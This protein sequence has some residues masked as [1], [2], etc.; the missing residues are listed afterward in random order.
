M[1]LEWKHPHGDHSHYPY[2]PVSSIRCQDHP[3]FACHEQD[4]E[5]NKEYGFL[6]RC[7][8]IGGD[9][10][11]AAYG[12]DYRDSGSSWGPA[13][14]AEPTFRPVVRDQ[15]SDDG[16]LDSSARHDSRTPTSA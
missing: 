6:S 1:K 10:F 5:E 2:D 15:A 16:H 13:W 8:G 3:Y 12:H 11:V 14:A 7:L 4:G 9:L